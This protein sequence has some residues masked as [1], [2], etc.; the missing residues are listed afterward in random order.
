MRVFTPLI[1]KGNMRKVV[2][3]SSGMGDT[4]FVAETNVLFLAL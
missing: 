2:A 4:D 3:I 1:Q